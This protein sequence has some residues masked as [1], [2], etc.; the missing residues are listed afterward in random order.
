V[1]LRQAIGFLG[2]YLEGVR[3]RYPRIDDEEVVRYVGGS[4][5]RFLWKRETRASVKDMLA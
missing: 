5:K 4:W 1:G 3:K 2:G